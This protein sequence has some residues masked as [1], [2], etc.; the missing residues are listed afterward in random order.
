MRCFE[1]CKAPTLWEVGNI[2]HTAAIFWTAVSCQLCRC[3]TQ[4]CY[5]DTTDLFRERHPVKA[6]ERGATV[7]A[8]STLWSL[9]SRQEQLTASGLWSRSCVQSSV[10]WNPKAERAEG[11]LG[12][13]GTWF[14]H[15]NPYLLAPIRGGLKPKWSKTAPC[16]FSFISFFRTTH[17]FPFRWREP[18]PQKPIAPF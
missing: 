10:H 9:A 5:A 7:F 17:I 12:S 2:Q 4:S 16:N 8:V 11:Q 14:A 6:V 13:T 18:Q 1:S 15:A 3:K